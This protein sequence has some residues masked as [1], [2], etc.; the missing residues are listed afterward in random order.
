MIKTVLYQEEPRLCQP[1]PRLDWSF[2]YR[3]NSTGQEK[4]AGKIL[5]MV[6]N[7]HLVIEPLPEQLRQ[8]QQHRNMSHLLRKVQC[9]AGLLE[10]ITAFRPDYEVT[11]RWKELSSKLT[12]LLEVPEIRASDSG[13]DQVS[14][15]P[16]TD[17]FM[18]VCFDCDSW[19][20]AGRCPI[21]TQ[22]LSIS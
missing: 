21:K 8:L 5:D 14:V 1:P 3:S 2:F 10:S 16:I 13:P 12:D 9:F 4:I 20:T 6:D 7:L 15:L 18:A 17:L 19:K 22:S 11:S